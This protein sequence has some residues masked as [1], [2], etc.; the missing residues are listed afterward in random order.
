M[1]TKKRIWIEIETE[2]LDR[3]GRLAEL[4]YRRSKTRMLSLLVDEAVE[5]REKKLGIDAERIRDN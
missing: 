3:V 4:D 2:M 5:A 1:K